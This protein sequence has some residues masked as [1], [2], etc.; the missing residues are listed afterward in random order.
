MRRNDMIDW[1]DAFENMAYIPG[2]ADLPG[3]WAEAAAAYRAEMARTGRLQENVAYGQNAREVLDVFTPEG[4]SRGLLIFV[5]GGYWR[6]FDKSF[7]SH[8]AQGCLSNG[9]TV[10]L[11][12]YPLAPE[13]RI[14]EITAC[15]TRA[16]TFASGHV[17]GPI[18]LAGHSA[19]GHLVTRMM[20]RGVLPDEV[21]PRLARV[22]SISGLHQ[23][24]PLVGIKLNDT[25]RLTPEE[26][27]A[28]SPA[29]YDPLPNVPLTAWV[30]AQERPEFLRQT[31]LIEE[32]W[33]L[34]GADVTAVYDPGHNHFTVI[35]ALEKPDSPLTKEI[36]R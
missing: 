29:A 16:V 8:L 17:P 24:G 18:R 11:P 5:H 14:S 3:Q 21:V 28:E 13:A 30:G 7:W 36:L 6:A 2:G 25:L 9:W 22:T 4:E 15:I 23:L 27:D 12:S 32:V 20:C 10:A 1:D 19:G 34:K 31:R 26:A 33:A 35:G